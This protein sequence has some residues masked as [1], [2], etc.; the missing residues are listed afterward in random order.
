[1]IL[2][3]YTLADPISKEIK[4]IGKSKNLKH[5]LEHHM[6]PYSL[7]ESWTPKNKWL[8]YLKNNNMKPIMEILDEGDENNIDDLEIYWIA[9]FK[10]WGF[11]LKN[12]TLGGQPPNPKGYKL[13]KEHVENLKLSIKKKKI[14]LQYNLDNTFIAEYESEKEAHR[15]T[16]LYHIGDCCRGHR[17]QCGEYYF[18]FKDNYFP[19]IK[20]VDYWTGTHHSKE[21]I[22]KMKMNHPLRKIICQYD[23]NTNK[24]LNEFDSSH[25]AEQKLGLCRNHITRCCK[26]VQNYN[27]V[28]GYYFR[29]KD[30]YFSYINSN[31]HGIKVIKMDEKYN[32]LEEFSSISKSIERGY[33]ISKIKESIKNNTMYDNSFWKII[34]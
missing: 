12:S 18:R 28:G 3:I 30:N 9:Q 19:Y 16:N 11:K 17:K 20:R 15:Q 26:G 32:I 25:E 5:R 8:R 33:N 10:A 7:K 21:S 13:K 29:F 27:S 1:M 14:V 2:F 22:N 4:Y 34:K 23:I 6:S 24:L 31:Y